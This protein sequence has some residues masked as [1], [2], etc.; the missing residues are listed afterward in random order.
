MEVVVGDE[1]GFAKHLVVPEE[2][3]SLPDP[4]EKRRIVRVL[5]A[6]DE[7]VSV[8]RGNGVVDSYTIDAGEY[9]LSEG[10]F[11]ALASGT[12]MSAVYNGSSLVRLTSTGTLVIGASK[13]I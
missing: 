6:P 3:H 5:R 12:L 7:T 9:G 4:G 2:I 1:L 10:A 13:D 11:E 8:V